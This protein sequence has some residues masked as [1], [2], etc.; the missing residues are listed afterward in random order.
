MKH[1]KLFFIEDLFE[2]LSPLSVFRASR[3]ALCVVHVSV[4]FWWFFNDECL[5]CVLARFQFK[6]WVKTH[7]ITWRRHITVNGEKFASLLQTLF[8]KDLN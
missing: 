1:S 5:V 2:I 4:S 8:W 3:M 6:K 7:F